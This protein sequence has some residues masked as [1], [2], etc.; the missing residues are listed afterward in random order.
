MN[1]TRT[2]VSLVCLAIFTILL[3]TACGRSTTQESIEPSQEYPLLQILPDPVY[4]QE[5]DD[6][7]PSTTYIASSTIKPA[8]PLQEHLTLQDLL[9]TA[10]ERRLHIYMPSTERLVE[11]TDGRKPN[12]FNML[13]DF[14]ERPIHS[15]LTLQNILHDVQLF[16]DILREVY[17]GYL[18]FGGDDVFLPIFDEILEELIR[19]DQSVWTVHNIVRIVHNG[20]G[21]VINDEHLSFGHGSDF[22]SNYTVLTSLEQFDRTERGFISRSNGMYVKEIVGHDK[23]KI[24]FLTVSPYGEFLY[25][26]VLTGYRNKAT[27]LTIIYENM[28]SEVLEMH[29]T[30]NTE[31]SP[32]QSPSLEFIDG[33]P[34]VTINQMYFETVGSGSWMYENANI[35]H[36]FV[37]KVRNEPAIIIDL[38]N[39]GGGNGLLAPR[40]LYNLVGEFVP[41]NR[42][43]LA[44]ESYD[45]FTYRSESNNP[46]NPS[47]PSNPFY[48]PMCEI[49]MQSV[50][51][52]FGDKHVVIYSTD[53]AR[54]MVMVENDQIIIF[55][56]SRHTRSAAEDFIDR[57]FNLEN[58]LV[59]GQNTGGKLFTNLCYPWRRLPYT[60]I[61]FGVGGRVAIHAEA[62]N[63]REGVGF[64]PDVWVNH[65][66]DALPAALAIL[67]N[68]F[69]GI[70][71]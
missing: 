49:R 64:A 6:D 12:T 17:G 45:F 25:T 14:T 70:E 4:S 52:P 21:P 16:F 61:S 43:Q 24:F 29:D 8:Y 7:A 71:S 37:D 62:H 27:S 56:T 66:D 11:L 35:F 34:I 13:Y 42:V 36:S 59:I 40:W 67:R 41:S 19:Q 69:Y 9:N 3:F 32:R 33:F 44:V 39:N 68:H 28:E 57:G 23:E 18:Y 54:G 53:P 65:P 26:P 50:S 22:L 38:R 47:N 5:Q 1:K 58:T 46:S 20:L 55:L 10:Y 48:Q 2:T 60:G 31:R 15:R 51:V 63:F 30:N